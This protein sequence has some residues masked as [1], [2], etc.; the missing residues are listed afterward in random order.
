MLEKIDL[1][2]N[3]NRIHEWIRAADQKVSIFLAFQGVVLTL[4]VPTV[5]QWFLKNFNELSSYSILLSITATTLLSCGI[6][7]SA[8]AIIPRLNS[9][10]KNKSLVFFG[11]IA[12][13]TPQDY[14]KAV[15][16]MSDKDYSEAL[17]EQIYISA[18]IAATKHS[19]F[20]DSVI[21]F[22]MGVLFL[23]TTCLVFVLRA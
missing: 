17:L 10:S 4:L 15:N 5:I 2:N 20:R 8:T 11:D 7:K 1:E 19:Q 9:K 16:R 21:L 22:L 3:L 6:Y 13:F 14:Q 23:I 12:T 18:K